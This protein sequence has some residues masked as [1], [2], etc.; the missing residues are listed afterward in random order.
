M[1]PSNWTEREEET[2]RSMWAA[3]TGRAIA[4]RLGKSRSAV[5]GKALRLGLERKAVTVLWTPEE[6]D[7][8]QSMWLTHKPQQIA[9]ALDRKVEA[10]VQK[11]KRLDLPPKHRPR[12]PV[13]RGGVP[14]AAT[15]R[16]K[17]AA[18]PATARVEAV[19]LPDHELE[20]ARKELDKMLSG[21]IGPAK[22]CQ[23]IDGHPD[24]G[25][26]TMCNAQ[27]TVKGSSWCAKHRKIVF[28]PYVPGTPKVRPVYD[29][30]K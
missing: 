9:E 8:L 7:K 24:T 21:N 22:T 18:K 26:Y 23:Y 19:V 13:S 6:T 5:L 17:P 4:A 2:L 1:K 29:R 28:R 11:A 30:R 12:Q 10:V 14:P 3:Y 16:P 15:P 27:P 20:E 25:K